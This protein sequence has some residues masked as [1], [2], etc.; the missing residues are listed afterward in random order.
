[1]MTSQTGHLNVKKPVQ[2]TRRPCDRFL[3]DCA[4][5]HCENCVA[6][7][8]PCLCVASASQR[9]GNRVRTSSYVGPFA[10]GLVSLLSIQALAQQG[11]QGPTPVA[12]LTPAQALAFQEGSR[13][14]S[15]NY[16]VADGLGPV[17]N[18]RSC[19]A[20]HRGGTTASNR[21]VVRFGRIANG[22]F[23]PL[24]ELGG[25][26]VQSRGIGSV[27]TVDGTFDFVAERVPPES[28][29]RATRRTTSLRG[30]GFVDAVP[31]QT[32]LDI[33]RA[34][35]AAGDGTAG[36]VHL[37]VDLAT[38]RTAVGKFGWKAQVPNLF[39]FSADALLNE[40][41]I[42]NP[43]FL[44]ETCPQ[45]DCDALAF[46]PT[47]A[48]ND[49]GRDVDALNDFQSML[50]APARG[51]ITDEVLAGEALFHQIG[52]GGCHRASLQTGPSPI[53]ALNRATFHPYSDFLLHDMG[54]LGDGIVQGQAAAREMRTAPL[55]G[56]RN[57]NRLL[58][59]GGAT[60]IDLAIQRHDGQARAARDRFAAL[61]ADSVA[62]LLAF[63]RSL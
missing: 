32:W 33:A 8:P 12:G 9:Q 57:S 38:G 14:F 42:T 35:A 27:T 50:A 3:L 61:D 43:L 52:C 44:D 2:D 4:L 5:S 24:A 40:I 1:M 41:G 51:T 53:A 49:D 23:D 13:T 31:D 62:L 59:D 20:C 28:S 46:N 10:L 39:Q 54:T 30:L 34:E 15:K 55:W 21:T 36:R 29:V 26:L 19:V 17:F 47:P 25:S 18:D 16:D 56:L 45:G 11:Q 58:H 63:L 7:P 48:L 6:Q 22:A 60:S 37:V